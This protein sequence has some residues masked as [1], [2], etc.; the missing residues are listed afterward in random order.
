MCVGGRVRLPQP[1]RPMAAGRLATAHSPNGGRSA[2]RFCRCMCLLFVF[3]REAWDDYSSLR[4]SNFTYSVLF[5]H[6]SKGSL[7]NF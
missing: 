3:G 7:W 4:S 2:A 6:L 1:I 5:S